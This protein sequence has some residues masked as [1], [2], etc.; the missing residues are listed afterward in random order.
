[1][2][3]LSRTARALLA[4]L[5]L[6]GLVAFAVPLL[7]AWR[8]SDGE[9]FRLVALVPLAAGI[10]LLL[11]CV[12]D[13][14]V[15]GQGTLAPWDPPRRL[16]AVGLYRRSRNPMYL[17]VVLIQIG[18]AVGFESW[19]LALYALVLMIGFHLRVVVAE[20]PWLARTFEREWTRYAARVPRWVFP[21]RRSLLLSLLALVAAVPV[22]GLF[23]EAYADAKA[24]RD[25]PPPGTLVDVGGRRLH[26]IC[27]GEGEPI[28]MFESSGFGIGSL[29]AATVRE[30]VA[31][32]ARVC[33]Y[34][35][36]GM[37]WSDPGPS[38]MTAGDLARDLAVLQDRAE[39][40]GRVILV[41][42]SVGG[43]TVEMFA[44]Q[45]PERV[46]GLAFLDAA[47]RGA[48]HAAEAR[49]GTVRTAATGASLA[50]HLGLIRLLDPFHIPRDTEEGRR[51]AAMT[52]SARS[53]DALG[54][55]LRGLPDT[56]NELAGA[57]ALPADVPLVVLSASNPDFLDLP[58]LHQ[59]MGE[60]SPVR[61]ASHQALAA[62]SPHG[63]WRVVPD[64]DH[65]IAESQ[66]EAV[67]EALFALI[68]DTR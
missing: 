19:G 25:F 47:S 28:V 5:A 37:G 39:L 32:R 54:A 52:Y 12:R 59:T 62:Q 43:L 29:S 44:R 50:A 36:A 10:G 66:P 58:W 20:E 42:S 8:T 9:P 46:A 24:G 18:W 56:L 30:R 34:D 22:A 14:L 31:A 33:S 17:A 3:R 1:V 63:S 2:R 21:G 64:S 23:Y 27:I 51:A 26:L 65:L 55:V 35:R 15:T 40:R 41:A 38:V 60:W 13:L 57:P 68:G 6:P 4:F 16:V 49:L 11:W 7:L 48:L 53:I 45:Y 61:L 67:I